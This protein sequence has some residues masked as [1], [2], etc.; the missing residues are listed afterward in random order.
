M[1]DGTPTFTKTIVGGRELVRCVWSHEGMSA[2]GAARI[3]SRGEADA[4]VRAQAQAQALFRGA[5][6]AAMMEGF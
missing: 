6:L 3:D 1:M 2:A 5:V 4:R